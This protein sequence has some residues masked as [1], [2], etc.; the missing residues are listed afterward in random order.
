MAKRWFAA[1]SPAVMALPTTKRVSNFRM[2]MTNITYNSTLLCVAWVFFFFYMWGPGFPIVKSMGLILYSYSW[3]H[4]SI[5]VVLSTQKWT[6]FLIFSTGHFLCIVFPYSFHLGP[7][8][9]ILFLWFVLW[10]LCWIK[11]SAIITT[12]S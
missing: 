11:R 7:G 12:F 6:L 10:S 3:G 9:C 2:L 1:M 8:V 5:L 4:Y